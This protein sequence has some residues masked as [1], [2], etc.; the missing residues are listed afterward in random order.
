MGNILRRRGYAETPDSANSEPNPFHSHAVTGNA[1]EDGGVA[2]VSMRPQNS[3]QSEDDR[4]A[5]EEDND[6]EDEEEEN[7]FSPRT[8]RSTTAKKNRKALAVLW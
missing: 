6:N 3:P 5:Q 1:E 4:L 2:M 7:P 8:R